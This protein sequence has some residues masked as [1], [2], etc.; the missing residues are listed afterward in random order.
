MAFVNPPVNIIPKIC[1]LQT[2]S[3]GG[4]YYTGFQMVEA[5]GPSLCSPKA[6]A[7]KILR[8]RPMTPGTDYR[9]SV[10]SGKDDSW[11]TA[12][13]DFRSQVQGEP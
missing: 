8:L 7:F 1:R 2:R 9:H 11:Q 6:K 10:F 4:A 3:S 5:Q 12:T 13:S